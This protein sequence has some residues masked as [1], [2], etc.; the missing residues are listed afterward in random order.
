MKSAIVYT[1]LSV[2]NLIAFAVCMCFLPAQV[3]VHFNWE[4]VCD[5]LGSP[6]LFI[7]LPAAAALVSAGL[8]ASLLSRSERNGKIIVVTLSAVGAVLAYLGWLSFALAAAGTALGAKT[9][10]PFGLAI[11]FPLSVLMVFFGNYLPRVKPNKTLGL[12]TPSTLKS[13][14]VWVRTHRVG[15]VLFFA[16]G[17]I[18]ACASIAFS[19]VRAGID[20]NFVSL[21]IFAVVVLFVC[22]FVPIYAR[23]LYRR[24]RRESAEQ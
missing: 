23:A 7:G 22:A 12:R 18:S 4:G 9:A 2:V 6:W 11:I 3:P 19:C 1:V 5:S 10:F 13:E 16:G 8:W 21:I 15:G 24:E 20:L 14:S 17:L